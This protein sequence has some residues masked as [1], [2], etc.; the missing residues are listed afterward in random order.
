MRGRSKT[1]L[2]RALCALGLLAGTSACLL[3]DKLPSYF[4][5]H[6][7]MQ[8]F[9]AQ[10]LN[11]E[12]PVA[13]ELLVVYDKKLLK[14]LEQ[15][16]ASQ[17]FA[18]REQFLK[19]HSG[20]KKKAL[21]HWKWEWVPGQVVP[22][23]ERPYQ[24]GVAGGVVFANYFTPGEHRASFDPFEPFLLNLQDSDFTVEPIE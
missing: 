21:D 13:V 7:R 3:P 17:W 5:G 24:V 9:V 14:S 11:L 4:G 18:K 6:V 12:S 23:Q 16:T 2:G 8:V 1:A 19:D 22:E 10:D 20:K 15:M